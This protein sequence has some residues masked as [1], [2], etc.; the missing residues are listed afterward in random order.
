MKILILFFQTNVVKWKDSV[1]TITFPGAKTTYEVN[2]EIFSS[3][4]ATKKLRLESELPVLNLA[5]YL[6]YVP[7]YTKFK[8]ELISKTKWAISHKKVTKEF[9][10]TGSSASEPRDFRVFWFPVEKVI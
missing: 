8:L 7:P 10:T 1:E 5:E 4:G 6:N 9:F 2:I 3:F